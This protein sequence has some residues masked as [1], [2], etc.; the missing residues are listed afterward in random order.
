LN[1]TAIWYMSYIPNTN[2]K[3]ETVLTIEDVTLELTKF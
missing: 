3:L 1:I 2:A